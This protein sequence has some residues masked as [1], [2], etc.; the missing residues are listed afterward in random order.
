MH[1]SELPLLSQNVRPSAVH[2]AGAGL[3]WQAP[4]GAEPEQV[5]A[6]AQ[7]VVEATKKQPSASVPQFDCDV[8]LAL[9]VSL[10]C[11]QLGST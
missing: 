4:V 11:A 3:H 6:E 8:V 7:A 10:P 9:K 5:C 2:C 1:V